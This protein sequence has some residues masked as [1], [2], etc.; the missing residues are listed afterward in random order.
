MGYIQTIQTKDGPTQI[1]YN[2]LANLPTSDKTL[3]LPGSFADAKV[4]GDE[5]AKVKSSTQP[6]AT[7]EQAQQIEQNTKN[8]TSLKED[9]VKKCVGKVAGLNK[10]DKNNVVNGFL[11]DAQGNLT[12]S[13][14]YFTSDYIPVF[15]NETVS[16]SRTTRKFLAYDLDKNPIESSYQTN[17]NT[18]YSYTPKVDGYIRISVQDTY[19]DGVMVTYTNTYLPST[20]YEP[21]QQC[22][23]ENVHMSNTLKKE[24]QKIIDN[25][26][27]IGNILY[28]KKLVACGDSFTKGDFTDYIDKNGHTGVNSDAYDNIRGMYKTYPWWIAERNNM[29]LVNEAVVGSTICNNGLR[30]D[31]F[32]IQRYKDI[33]LDAD[34]IILKFG[35]NDDSN[36]QNSPIG[37]I[38]DETNTTYFGA[39]NV[40]LKYLITQYPKAKIGVI[41][42]NGM[43][44]A[45]VEYTNAIIYCC[46]RWGVAYLDEATDYKI[47]ALLRV[48]STRRTELCDEAYRIRFAQWTVA[49]TNSHPNLD[50]HKFE[51]TIVEN[52]LRGL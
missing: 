23:E 45:S 30:A 10:F 16:V 50:A 46:R 26:K 49:E 1:D 8:I 14:V 38:E 6:G 24:V 33:P 9:L 13:A 42:T 5:I 39:W 19:I 25:N 28:G 2:A 4:V 31:A 35:I 18:N 47:P 43:N 40:V 44:G 41:I 48:D 20:L 21:Y 36:H 29:I 7:T 27:Y 12:D 34:Y 15:A 52:W 11:K 17:G 51:S 32:S 3:T 37:T 22:A